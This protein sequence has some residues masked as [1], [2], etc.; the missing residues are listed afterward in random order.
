MKS[1]NSK[2]TAEAHVFD[3]KQRN[4]LS[5]VSEVAPSK[6]NHFKKAFGQKSLRSAITSKC[7][8]CVSFETAEVRR[9]ATTACPLHAVR[10]YQ[11]ARQRRED[12]ENTEAQRATAGGE[13]YARTTRLD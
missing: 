10:P 3:E 4:M 12:P 2:R 9:C 6:L 11:E 13:N 8:E 7:L 1:T 5:V